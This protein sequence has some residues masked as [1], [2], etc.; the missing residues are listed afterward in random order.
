M[1]VEVNAVDGA[2]LREKRVEAGYSQQ[3]LADALFV[4]RELVSKWETGLRTPDRAS[5]EK[6]AELLGP[7][8][9]ALFD[10]ADMMRELAG[11]LPDA[12]MSPQTLTALLDGFLGTLSLRDRSV[13]VRRYCFAEEAAV[14]G[15]HYGLRDN[16]VRAVLARTRRK[17]KKYLEAKTR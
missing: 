11:C 4:S 17:L 8:C 5:R 15:A 10:D 16:H 12:A 1:T 6:L 3:A 14:I 9:A 13:F 2:K 7:E